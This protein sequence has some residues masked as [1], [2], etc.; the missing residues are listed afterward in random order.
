MSLK[1]F[2]LFRRESILKTAFEGGKL[3]R[4]RRVSR[5]DRR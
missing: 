3:K 2:R 1:A 5:E 4:D